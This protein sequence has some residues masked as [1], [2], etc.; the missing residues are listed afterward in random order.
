MTDLIDAHIA[1]IRAGGYAGTTT[2]DREELLRRM[3]RDLPMGLDQA[4]TE[5][6]ADWL[7]RP[8]WSA[9]TRATYYTHLRGFYTWACHPNSPILDWD[10]SAGLI[11]PRR[12]DA[13]PRPCT[14]AEL[15]HI[16]DHAVMP[17]GTWARLAAFGGLRC[18]E[19][20]VIDRVDI[21]SAA[22]HLRGKGG[23]LATVPMHPEIW[24]VVEP[25]PPGPVARDI[26]GT[27]LTP[28]QVSTRAGEYFRRHLHLRVS[29]HKLRHW[30]GTNLLRSGANIRVVQKNMR[31]KTLATTARY[32]AVTDR[33]REI[34]VAALPV[35][36]TDA[37]A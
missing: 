36:R 25:L 10:P 9:E 19:I 14:D 33:E 2:A 35:P 28:G 4:T 30:Y 21:T 26:D 29:M 3:D 34:A 27:R 22:L 13:E 5:E 23:V 31:H 1:H 16:L 7:A 32:T 20:S 37:P 11:R 6:L 12:P 18:C 24:R 8:G 15:A 17:Y